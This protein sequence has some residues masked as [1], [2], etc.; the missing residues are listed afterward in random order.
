M[1][2]IS[3]EVI[4]EPLGKVSTARNRDRR[5]N[6]PACATVSLAQE[7][8]D[9]VSAEFVSSSRG[10]VEVL[11]NPENRPFLTLPRP[12]SKNGRPEV[13]ETCQDPND[14]RDVETLRRGGHADP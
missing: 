9:G 11:G 12:V 4:H 6:G 8:L 5:G 7:P 14:F 1:D 13:L 10:K 3:I 2:S